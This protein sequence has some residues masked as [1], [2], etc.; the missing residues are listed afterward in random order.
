MIELPYGDEDATFPIFVDP[1]CVELV[2]EREERGTMEDPDTGDEL[3]VVRLRTIIFLKGR[4]TKTAT[5]TAVASEVATIIAAHQGVNNGGLVRPD[6]AV[7]DDKKTVLRT[8]AE[9]VAEGEAGR[10]ALEAA[11]AEAQMTGDG[12]TDGEG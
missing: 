10:S 11:A 1:D 6:V 2:M 4:E 5:S 3:S 9:I 8:A 7:Y 12:D